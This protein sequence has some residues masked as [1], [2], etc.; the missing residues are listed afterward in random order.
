MTMAGKTVTI[1]LGAPSGGT[2][3]VNA[4]GGAMIWTPATT[5]TD[6]AA[7][8]GSAAPVTEATPVDPEF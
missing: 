6:R 1:V 4:P 8:A 2:N 5:T 3:K 7:N